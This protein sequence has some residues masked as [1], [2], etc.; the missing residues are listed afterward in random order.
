MEDHEVKLHN[1]AYLSKVL[2][3]ASS[4]PS[5]VTRSLLEQQAVLHKESYARQHT[6]VGGEAS[7]C[8]KCQMPSS[9]S[10]LTPAALPHTLHPCPRRTQSSLRRIQHKQ[11]SV[12]C[13]ISAKEKRL[14]QAY[15]NCCNLSIMRCV[16]CGHK[17]HTLCALPHRQHLLGIRKAVN[18]KKSAAARNT[19]TAVS[20]I[21]VP[22]IVPVRRVPHRPP[23]VDCGLIISSELKLQLQELEKQVEGSNKDNPKKRKKK[24]KKVETIPDGSSKQVDAILKNKVSHEINYL[25]TPE[26][27]VSPK[28]MLGGKRMSGANGQAV[29][30]T[31]S[32][33]LRV[34]ANNGKQASKFTTDAL[35][36]A[37]K[38]ST[39]PRQSSLKSF[40]ETLF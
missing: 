38:K 11:K 16:V 33:S 34:Q 17:R 28:K 20:K 24:K 25:A 27:N 7:V 5:D 18:E 22:D 26:S 8:P 30:C 23:E 32:S 36:N 1:A 2:E 35:K 21:I 13:K 29:N 3:L 31:Q 4:L 14:L 40:L 37:L 12:A 39:A 9:A 6:G 19:V 10:P 15:E